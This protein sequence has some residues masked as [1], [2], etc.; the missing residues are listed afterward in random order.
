[1]GP[2]RIL[3]PSSHEKLWTPMFEI[4]GRRLSKSIGLSWFIGDVRGERAIRHG[5][6]DIGFNTALLLLPEKK[7]GVVVLCNFAPAPATDLAMTALDFV[8][9]AKPDEPRPPA[10]IPVLATLADQGVEAAVKKW[11]AL[12][13]DFP[14]E[15]DFREQLFLDPAGMAVNLDRVEDAKLLAELLR[16]LLSERALTF[17]SGYIDRY[18]AT[19]PGHE[20]ASAVREILREK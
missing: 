8:L 4:G 2:Q 10:S 1:M 3:D 13:R 20:A 6:R 14:E 15:Y 7:I 18:L 17:A 12:R 5:G 11:H 9:G 16:H 19:H